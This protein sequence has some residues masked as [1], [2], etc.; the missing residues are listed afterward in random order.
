MFQ[1]I[2]FPKKYNHQ[3]FNYARSLSATF[4]SAALLFVFKMLQFRAH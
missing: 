4:F 1:E 2:S 3:G